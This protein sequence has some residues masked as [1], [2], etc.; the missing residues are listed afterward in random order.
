MGA[1]AKTRLSIFKDPTD[2]RL[3]RL[4][5]MY[6]MVVHG[7]TFFSEFFSFF[8]TNIRLARFALWTFNSFWDGL[9][10]WQ[11]NPQKTVVKPCRAGDNQIVLLIHSSEGI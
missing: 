1:S 3:L 8:S 10:K 11:K 7:A 6:L 5:V 4:L 2:K 9:R